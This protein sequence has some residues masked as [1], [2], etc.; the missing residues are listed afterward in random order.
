MDAQEKQ[1]RLEQFERKCRESGVPFTGQRRAILE[2]VLNSDLHPSA[3]QVFEAVRAVSRGVS[4]ATVHRNLEMMASMGVISKTCHPGAVAR[5]EARTD[6]HHHLI[7]LR[8]NSVVD[9]DD[10]NLN[11]LQ[12]PDTSAFE[13]EV[14]D[15]RVQIRG[16]CKEC[17]GKE[18]RY[19]RKG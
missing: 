14:T 12:V 18:P 3:H 13:F 1:A 2:A 7:C 6:L 15:F 11:A 9:I 4:K 5:Y 17:R 19:P 8:C 10:E 16:Y